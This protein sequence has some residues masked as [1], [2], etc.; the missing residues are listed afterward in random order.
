MLNQ[1]AMMKHNPVKI[2]ENE[3]T[4]Q[5]GLNVENLKT[6]TVEQ[7]KEVFTTLVFADPVTAW[8]VIQAFGYDLWFENV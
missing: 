2:V 3:F 7:L 4:E 1:V 5:M 8:K 6:M